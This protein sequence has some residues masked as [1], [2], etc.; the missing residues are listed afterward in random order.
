MIPAST[1]AAKG[2][3]ILGCCA[4]IQVLVFPMQRSSAMGEFLPS[5]L[6][7]RPKIDQPDML[8]IQI[9]DGRTLL[10]RCYLHIMLLGDDIFVILTEVIEIW[11]A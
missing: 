10:D 1:Y 7:L 2:A 8:S 3:L 6:E 9:S 11:I 4:P 5:H